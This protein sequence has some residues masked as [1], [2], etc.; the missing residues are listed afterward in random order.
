MDPRPIPRVAPIQPQPTKAPSS[1]PRGDSADFARELLEALRGHGGHAA[2]NTVA[3][4]TEDRATANQPDPTDLAAADPFGFGSDGS[5][6]TDTI[7]Q[8]S[9]RLTDELSARFD[10]LFAEQGIDTN[11]QIE[12]RA[13]NFGRIRVVGDHPDTEQIEALFADSFELGQGFARLSSAQSLLRAEQQYK[14]FAAAYA[15][16]PRGAVVRYAHLFSATAPEPDFRLQYAEG[17][18]TTQFA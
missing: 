5:I 15:D 7:S 16:D 6:S 13:D 12:L 3:L 9:E 10:A 11:G 1:R 8:R 17:E 18:W 14:A 2:S 4:R